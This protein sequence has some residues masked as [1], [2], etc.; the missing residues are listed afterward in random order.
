MRFAAT[1][2]E[3]THSELCTREATP[4]EGLFTLRGP[5]HHPARGAGPATP[6]CGAPRPDWAGE[7]KDPSGESRLASLLRGALAKPRK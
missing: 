7:A 2:L 5:G 1:G 4:A 6:G 3:R